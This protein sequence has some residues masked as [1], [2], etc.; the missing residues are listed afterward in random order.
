[1][2]FFPI[3]VGALIVGVI[4]TAVGLAPVGIPLIVIGLVV[5]AVKLLGPSGRQAKERRAE[6]D[7]QDGRGRT[8]VAT[9]P[10]HAGQEHMTPE[11][12]APER[13]GAR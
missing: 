1:M 5:A 7:A 10:A 6:A 4:T 2:W 3:I 11:Q 13:R 8:H 12:I 9:G